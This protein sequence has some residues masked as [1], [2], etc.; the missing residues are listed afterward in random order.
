MKSLL[1][2]LAI[3]AAPLLAGAQSLFPTP[4]TDGTAPASSAPP[5]AGS[6]G[7]A[8]ST[9]PLPGQGNGPS[10]EKN[11]PLIPEGGPSGGGK[12]RAH[13]THSVTTSPESSATFQ[14]EQD[15]MDRIRLRKAVTRVQNDPAIQAEWVAA[16][17]QRTDPER[18]AA[19]AQYYN[20]LYGRVLKLEPALADKIN[21][22][23]QS[24]LI[25]MRN[26]RL[27]ADDADASSSPEP[28]AEYTNAEERQ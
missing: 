3:L 25:R 21:A 12:T 28:G 5:A 1:I 19:L 14:T 15:I 16:H 22:R 11:L 18:R 2:F 10:I 17:Q 23:K 27:D 4:E 13:R 24:A 26:P 20:H 8:A 7:D 6:A 9:V